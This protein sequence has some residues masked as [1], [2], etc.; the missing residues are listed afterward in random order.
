MEDTATNPW[1][2]VDDLQRL[3]WSYAQDFE[4][5]ILAR[6]LTFEDG[7]FLRAEDRDRIPMLTVP[8]NPPDRAIPYQ[9][10]RLI[11]QL[12]RELDSRKRPGRNRM[13]PRF[14]QP[15]RRLPRAASAMPRI[16]GRA[17]E[18]ASRSSTA[19]R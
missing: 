9:Q 13:A 5:A 11:W 4:D 2:T 8:Y 6:V 1:L 14:R 7:D 15:A 16:F 19:P 3:F 18:Q 12:R 10:V 17:G